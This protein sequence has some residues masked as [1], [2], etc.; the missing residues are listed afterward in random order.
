M[1]AAKDIFLVFGSIFFCIV[2]G[3]AV[4]EHLG[5]VPQWSK[6]PPSSLSMFQGDYGLAAEY[7]WMLVH[8]ATLLLLTGA[9]ITNWKN[10]RRRNI[11][12]VLGSYLLILVITSVWFV[13]ELI[14]ITHT[15]YAEAADPDL[16]RRASMWEAMSL[17][18]L[19]CLFILAVVLMNTLLKRTEVELAPKATAVPLAYPNDSLGG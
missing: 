16:T 13:P 3:G 17:V 2:L 1:N 5:V 11:L 9:L 18:R 4:Y 12:I 10:M 19:F 8:P 15:P 6:A 14:S 7:F